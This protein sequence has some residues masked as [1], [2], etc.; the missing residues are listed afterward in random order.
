MRYIMSTPF[1]KKLFIGALGVIFLAAAALPLNLALAADDNGTPSPWDCLKSPVSCALYYVTLLINSILGI[2]VALA[3]KIT[4]IALEINSFVASKENPTV[5]LGFKMTLALAN[6]GFVAAIVV[7]AIATILRMQSYGIKQL[8]WRLVVAALL[9]NFSITIAGAILNVSDGVAKY[10]ISA[11]DPTTSDISYFSFAGKL[12]AAF[13]PQALFQPPDPNSLD[14]VRAGVGIGTSAETSIMDQTF[15]AIF[16]MIFSIIFMLIIAVTFLA[17]GI[18]LMIRYVYVSI[19]LILMP[20]VW[21]MWIFPSFRHLWKKWWDKF[22]SW[23]FFLPISMFFIYLALYTALNQQSWLAA[24]TN[25]AGGNDPATA[26]VLA[27]GNVGI[28]Q[29]AGQIIVTIGLVLGGLFAANKL[30]PAGAAIATAA[31][32]GIVGATVLKGAGFAA[33]KIASGAQKIGSKIPVPEQGKTGFKAGMQRLGRFATVGASKPLKAFG[34]KAAG[35][36]LFPHMEIERDKKG[37]PIIDE[38]TGQ[39]KTKFSAG[40]LWD[41]AMAAK[42]KNALDLVYNGFKGGTGLFKKKKKFSKKQ[43]QLLADQGFDVEG[44]DEDAEE[45]GGESGEEAGGAPKPKI[46]VVGKG[47]SIKP[48]DRRA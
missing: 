41:T 8:L 27:T 4:A 40:S 3:A 39:P 35:A 12:A 6:L 5:Q 15:T 25:F 32:S 2:L 47:Y 17:L 28:V 44:L 48:Q 7:I 1:R 19:L 13:A 30:A 22:L 36:K 18:L 21:L 20:L 29:K 46:D 38:K 33:G 9:V 24:H 26:L 42:G 23:A 11:A 10:F 43:Q 14:L 37:R 31:A 45:A 16:N 34:Q